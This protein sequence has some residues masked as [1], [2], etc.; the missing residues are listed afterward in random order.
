MQNKPITILGIN[1]GARYL[2]IAIFHG[3]EL[4]EWSVKVIKGEW[5][6]KKMIKIKDIVAGLIEQYHP[7]VLAIKK[8]HQAKS[9][10]NLDKLIE[11]LKQLAKTKKLPIYEFPF[12]Y[13][14]AFLSP[15]KKINK[16]KL[17]KLM[18][19][20][21]SM[22]FREWEKENETTKKNRENDSYKNGYYMRMFEAVLVAYVC[23]RQL[24]RC[25][26]DNLRIP[27]TGI[28]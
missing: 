2:G 25:T 10:D 13:I 4:R 26:D 24:D 9:S 19:E 14:E 21:Y 17:A 8:L 28:S 12:K 1:P 20:K 27:S 22:L 5:S 6:K 23:F 15:G 3:A 18:T 7:D 11:E 16:L